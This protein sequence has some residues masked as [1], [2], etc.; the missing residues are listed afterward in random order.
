MIIVTGGAGF[1]GSNLLAGLEAAGHTDLV[2]VDILGSDEKWKNISKR[3]VRDIIPPQNLMAY[4]DE[5]KKD[6]KVIFHLGAI[7]STTEY[8]ADLVIENNFTLTRNL[9]RWC[10]VH[11]VRL[12][13]ASSAAT[14][15]AGENGFSDSDSLEYL[16]KLR[17]LNPYGWSKHVFD[18]RVADI[19]HGISNEPKPP[20]WAGLKFF[21]VYGPNEYHKGSQASV[22]CGLYPQV[23]V[24]ANARLFKSYHPNYADGGQLRDFVY[25][26]DCVDVM[27]WLM[28]HKNVSG[29]FNIG[30]GKARSFK[31]L[32]LATFAAAQKE[33]KITYIDMPEVLKGKYQ[34]FTQADLT[35]LRAAGYTKPMTE[36]EDGVRL[37][38]QDFM[39]REDRYR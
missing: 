19:V 3:A 13:Y 21:N 34:Y 33:P 27:L 1:I 26:D 32:A 12:I 37:Y 29:L 38:V 28:D 7:S 31:D 36:L 4:L 30:S 24:G 9:W 11:D 14:Y 8:N 17:P 23:A 18:R 10:A 5:H 2:V 25:V 20:Q 15:G 6:V 35:K 39:A 16:A 22:V